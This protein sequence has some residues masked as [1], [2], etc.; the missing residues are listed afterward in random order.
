MNAQS[1]IK[2]EEKLQDQNIKLVSKWIKISDKIS[3]K[4]QKNLLVQGNSTE[5]PKPI[6]ASPKFV[7][8][9]AEEQVGTDSRWYPTQICWMEWLFSDHL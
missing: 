9:Q 1:N 5:G 8:Q 4:S 3:D 2:I 7:L 6:S